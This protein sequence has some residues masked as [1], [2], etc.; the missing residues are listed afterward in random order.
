MLTLLL[1]LTALAQDPAP[2]AEA[3]TKPEAAADAAADVAPAVVSNVALKVSLTTTGGKSKSGNVIRI[4]RG[5]D[6]YGE[7]GW[8]DDEKSLKFYVES[9]KE[10]K[11][12]TWPEVKTIS[13]KVVNAKDIDCL[14]SSDYTPWMYECGVK[15]TA[16]LTTKDGKRYTADSGHKWRFFFDDGTESEFWL[17]RHYSHQQDDRPVQ[18]GDD[19]ENRALYMALQTEL[20]A[21]LK[22]SLTKTIS[23]K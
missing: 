1:T 3:E 23:V 15:L 20:K 14:Y 4:E 19:T 10:T 13:I 18:L 17:K 12:I 16:Q 9:D 8:L 5:E 7:K 6:I 2:P 22:S 21:E 11:K